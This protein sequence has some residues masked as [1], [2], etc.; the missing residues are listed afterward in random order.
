MSLSFRQREKK[1]TLRD[2]TGIILLILLLA[3]TLVIKIGLDSRAP[4]IF[5]KPSTHTE[6]RLIDINSADE[7]ELTCL[8]GIGP[9][10]ARRIISYRQTHGPFRSADELENVSG[11]GPETVRM[12]SRLVRI[13]P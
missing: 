1:H 12:I 10:K 8:P 5:V 7:K 3:G 11:L 9:V 13:R 4:E 2:N 6:P